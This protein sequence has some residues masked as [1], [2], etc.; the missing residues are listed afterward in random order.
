MLEKVLGKQPHTKN[1][2]QS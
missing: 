2:Y 1:H